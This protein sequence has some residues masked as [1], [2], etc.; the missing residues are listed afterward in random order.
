M[1]YSHLSLLT[2]SLLVT[3]LT[4]NQASAD[5]LDRLKEV[6]VGGYSTL[7]LQQNRHEKIEAALDELSLILKWDN[8]DRVKFFAEIELENPMSWREGGGIKGNRSYLDVERLYL[9][10]SVSDQF[11]VRTGRFLTPVGRWNQLHASPLVWTTSRPVATSRLFPMA[12]NGLMLHGTKPFSD[13]ALEYSV[14]AET[15]KDQN[16]EAY[17]LRF[18]NARGA[19]LMYSG[20]VDVGATVMEF[21]ELDLNKREYRMLSLDFIKAHEGWEI[22]GEAFFRNNKNNHENT[23]GAY[24]QG[25]APLGNKWFLIG[26]LENFKATSQETVERAV[27]GLTWRFKDTQLFKIEYAGGHQVDPYMPVGLM[28]SLAIL[29]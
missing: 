15:L 11:N 13:G 9:D 4:G 21:D 14:F 20:L 16:V 12:L 19:R 22:S 24:L 27:V 5:V 2:I 23:G 29:F 10:Y 26:R 8:Q 17:E 1:H 3:L 25:V 28:T 7:R 18:R 6:E